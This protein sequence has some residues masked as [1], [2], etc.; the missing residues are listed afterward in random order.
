M[1]LVLQTLLVEL[2]NFLPKYNLFQTHQSPYLFPE[3]DLMI[4]SPQPLLSKSLVISL[5]TLMTFSPGLSATCPLLQYYCSL[6]T[7]ETHMII[8][9]LLFTNKCYDLCLLITNKC[10]LFKNS[11]ETSSSPTTG[12][13]SPGCFLQ[14]ANYLNA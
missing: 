8:L 6:H 11:I 14:Y 3:T 1:A 5:S 7:S 13:V 10:Y 2:T 4:I 12:L 9:C